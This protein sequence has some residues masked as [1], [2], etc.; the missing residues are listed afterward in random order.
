MNNRWIESTCLRSKLRASGAL[1]LSDAELVALALDRGANQ[2]KSIEKAHFLLSSTNYCILEIGKLS[3]NQLITDHNLTE[4]EAVNLVSAMELGRRRQY[5]EAIKQTQIKKS[6]EIAAIFIPMLGD[7]PIEEMWAVYLNRNNRIIKKEKHSQGHAT[8]TVVDG[9]IIIKN[10][11]NCNAEGII[12]VHNHPSGNAKPSDSDQSLTCK[13]KTAANYF[14]IKIIDH[15]I[16]T[17]SNYYSFADEG[18]L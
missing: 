5:A 15:V 18:I 6:K 12:L 10:A 7:L 9:K 4:R 11:L 3:I 14:E 2:E 13:I 16:V 1:S 17:E 8:G